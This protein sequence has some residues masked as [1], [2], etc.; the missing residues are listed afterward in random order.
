MNEPDYLAGQRS[1]W[2]RLLQICL[3][4]LGADS[5]LASASR[6]VLEREQAIVA[7]RRVCADFGDNEWEDTLHLADVIEKHL[8]RR[9]LERDYANQVE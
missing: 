5:E 9:L 2:V 7:L 1:A 3:K 6:W 8:E 4:E